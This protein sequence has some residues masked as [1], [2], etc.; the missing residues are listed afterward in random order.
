LY[1]DKLKEEFIDILNTCEQLNINAI[2]F[3]IRPAADAFYSSPYEPWSEWLTGKQGRPPTPFFDPLEFM[4]E[5]SHKEKY[6]FTL[7]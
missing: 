2:I 4:I 7:G 6:N 3:Q 5:E 1:A